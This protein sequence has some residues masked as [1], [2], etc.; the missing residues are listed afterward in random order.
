MIRQILGNCVKCKKERA[1]LESPFM[2]DLPKKRVKMGEKPFSNN[3]VDYFES[4]LVK[5]KIKKN[6]ETRPTKALTKCYRVIF[7]CLTTR[8]IHIRLAGD[9]STDSFL[10]ALRRFISRRGNVK[11]M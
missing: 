2:G 4:Y 1:M 11:A 10:L 5:K 6:R 9:L 7:T 3:G 8:T